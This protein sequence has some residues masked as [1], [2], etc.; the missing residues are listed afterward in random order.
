MRRIYLYIIFSLFMPL[1]I[2][3]QTWGTNDGDISLYEIEYFDVVPDA[4]YS[5]PVRLCN[6]NRNNIFRKTFRS[7]NGDNIVSVDFFD[8]IGRRLE[9]V[10]VGITP[11]RQNLVSYVEYDNLG[12]VGKEWLPGAMPFSTDYQSREACINSSIE[13]NGGDAEPHSILTYETSPM[14]RIREEYGSGN[15]WHKMRKAVCYNY[16]TNVEGNDTL[17]CIMYRVTSSM[18]EIGVL[19]EIKL[20]RSYPTGSIHITAISDED[21][22]TVFEFKDRKKQTILIRRIGRKHGL[23]TILDTYYI[24]D[25]KGNLLAVLPPAM[26]S[27]K[28][29]AIS[30]EMFSKYGY[31]YKYDRFNRLCAKKLPGADWIFM[32]RDGADRIVYESDGE[33]R[34][35]NKNIFHFYDVFGRECVTGTCKAVNTKYVYDGIPEVLSCRYTG[36]NTP[37]MGYTANWFQQ[38]SCDILTVKYYDNYRFINDDKKPGIFLTSACNNNSV[39]NVDFI[40]M[41]DS[42]TYH[43]MNGFGERTFTPRGL[44]TGFVVKRID[45]GMSAGYDYHV[46][47]YDRFS[48]PVQT[49]STNHLGG[50]DSDYFLYD[51]TGAV[52]KHRHLHSSKFHKK[53]QEDYNYS[54]YHAGRL[55]TVTHSV[56]GNAPVTLKNNSYDELGRL[57]ADAVNGNGN[58]RTTYTYN[59]RSWQ[60]EVESGLHSY[61]LY[62]NESSTP[63]YNGDISSMDWFKGNVGKYDFHYDG[64]GR[65]EKAEYKTYDGSE[66]SRFNTSYEYD[67]MGN[68]ISLT[69]KGLLDDGEYGL[70]DNLVLEYDGNR[71][72]CATDISGEGPLYKGA[73]H[74]RDGSDEAFE[75]SYDRNGNMTKDLNKEICKIEYNVLNLPQKVTMSNNRFVKY[76]YS[77]TGDKLQVIYS[78]RGLK[79]IQ[80]MSEVMSDRSGNADTLSSSDI[81]LGSSLSDSFADQ[82]TLSS[83]QNIY[84]L[85]VLDYCGNIV[86]SDDKPVKIL[87]DGGYVSIKKG[88][89]TYHFFLRDHLGNVRVVA[90]A[91]GNLEERNDYYPFGGLMGKGLNGD[92][93]SYKYNGKELERQIGLDIYDYGARRYDA[94]ICRFTTMDPLAEKYYST[95]PYAYC[96]NNPVKFIDPDGKIVVVLDENAKRNIMNTLSAAE[97]KYVQFDQNG[98]LNHELL[99]KYDGSSENFLALKTLSESS[100]NY[101]FHVSDKDINGRSF[102]EKGTKLDNPDNYFY[103]V[104]NLPNAE[105]DPSPDENVYIFTASF[106]DKR[107]QAKN[108]AHEGYGHAYF[109]ELS[110]K[111]SSINPNHIFEKIDSQTVYDPEFNMVVIPIFGKTNTKL[112]QQIST[113]EQQALKNYDKKNN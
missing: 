58:L 68:I 113:V 8:D 51:F 62:Y 42:L 15:D 99:S 30:P 70:V 111:D 80:P 44:V 40:S 98:I 110:K 54:Y 106:L 79:L 17:D 23:R 24:Y 89:P 12:R 93:Q 85:P 65:L 26:T 55:L 13:T 10:Q 25:H 47:Y 112:E 71:L 72:V 16:M 31:A 46:T 101:F 104:T 11:G 82:S 97:A 20:E 50:Y 41:S 92:F 9:T 56:D 86:Y 107:T 59:V 57:S 77:A 91:N 76:T 103:G 74:F 39:G 108:T 102:Y 109:Y 37:Y 36:D 32:I 75:Y 84:G 94:A 34:A 49:H 5:P 38:G 1:C 3:S 90:D 60:K 95:S 43:N 87:F 61:H 63:R 21:G 27:T 67:R 45:G 100:T 105:N 18:T 73:F 64:V 6:S 33:M 96:V 88:V 52:L 83:S 29:D 48:R 22:M 35:A 81:N 19:P 53:I 66:N 4:D 78:V 2:F 14:G 69:R 7:V 28:N